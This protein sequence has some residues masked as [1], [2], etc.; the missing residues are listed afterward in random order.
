MELTE[1]II[2]AI[3]NLKG[4]SIVKIDFS[5]IEGAVCSDFIICEGGS[6]T[7]VNAIAQSVS[8]HTKTT[9]K[10]GPIGRDG[11][12]DAEWIIVDYGSVMVHVFQRA[13]RELYNLESLWADAEIT[14]IPDLD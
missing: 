2:E 10:T 6:N 9:L 5:K 4:T 14:E 12:D 3:Q 1:V 8:K 11:Q 13:T 7:H